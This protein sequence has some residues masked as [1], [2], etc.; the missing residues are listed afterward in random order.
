[1]NLKRS[2]NYQPITIA[3]TMWTDEVYLPHFI[4]SYSTLT[5]SWLGLTP[6]SLESLTVLLSNLI[7]PRLLSP[8][9]IEK[10]VCMRF[11]VDSLTV[12]QDMLLLS[13]TNQFQS[14]GGLIDTIEEIKL[15]FLKDL[16]M[17][18][19]FQTRSLLQEE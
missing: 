14:S 13:L 2:R 19:S 4:I 6:S 18:C 5:D 8:L 7:V 17:L 9:L 16:S 12:T 1:M 3:S 10:G 11:R 15:T